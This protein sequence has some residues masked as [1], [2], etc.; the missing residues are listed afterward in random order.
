MFEIWADLIQ[1][2]LLLT[3]DKLPQKFS[4]QVKTFSN[5]LY[6]VLHCCRSFMYNTVPNDKGQTEQLQFPRGRELT[7]IIWAVCMHT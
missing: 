1:L 3:E 5:V 6:V 4:T 2:C 7:T